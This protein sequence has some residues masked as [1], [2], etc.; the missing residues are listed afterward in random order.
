MRTPILCSNVFFYKIWCEGYQGERVILRE[1]ERCRITGNVR[2][3]GEADREEGGAGDF[4][5]ENALQ[6]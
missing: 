2:H 6:Q 1:I 5:V 3:T 4:G